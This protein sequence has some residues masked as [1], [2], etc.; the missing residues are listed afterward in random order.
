[1]EGNGVATGS[2]GRIY[3]VGGDYNGTYENSYSTGQ[4]TAAGGSS[5]VGGVPPCPTGHASPGAFPQLPV[6][7][8]SR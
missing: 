8:P 5:V 6:A 1:M 2:D 7:Q 3:S 4:P